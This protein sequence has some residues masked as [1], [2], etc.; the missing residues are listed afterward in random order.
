MP[1]TLTLTGELSLP[2]HVLLGR[3]MPDVEVLLQRAGL[4]PSQA[5]NR[6]WRM[7]PDTPGAYRLTFT[8]TL[9]EEAAP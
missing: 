9:P 1:G 7:D 8:V 5:A 6:R 2:A 4:L 3:T